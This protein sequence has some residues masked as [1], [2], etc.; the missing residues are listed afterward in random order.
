M[1]AFKKSTVGRLVAMVTFVALSLPGHAGNTASGTVRLGVVLVSTVQA[2]PQPAAQAV[3]SAMGSGVT[4]R[5]GAT[6][7]G[8][9]GQVREIVMAIA[10]DALKAESAAPVPANSTPQVTAK[11]IQTTFVAE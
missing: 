2:E 6:N 11:L 7:P 9:N 10:Q 8:V 3:Q 4:L 1:K 5:M